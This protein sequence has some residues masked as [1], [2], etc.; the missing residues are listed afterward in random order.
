MKSCGGVE[1]TMVMKCFI[2]QQL[3][4]L[5]CQSSSKVTLGVH[6]RIALVREALC[7]IVYISHFTLGSSAIT[8]M[9]AQSKTNG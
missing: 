4:L 5:F 1:T 3:W 6:P 2:K 8:V 9:T 7:T